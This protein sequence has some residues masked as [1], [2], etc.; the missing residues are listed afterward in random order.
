[1]RG[2]VRAYYGSSDE[3]LL[4]RRLLIRSFDNQSNCLA[5]DIDAL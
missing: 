5:A 1:M 2:E 4:K 3:N